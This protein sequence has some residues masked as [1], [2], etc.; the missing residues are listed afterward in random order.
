MFDRKLGLYDRCTSRTRL[1]T[2]VLR[3]PTEYLTT[4]MRKS[5]FIHGKNSAFSVF[6][7]ETGGRWPPKHVNNKVGGANYLVV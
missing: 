4:T 3:E 1:P 7:A 2:G 5:A 6:I